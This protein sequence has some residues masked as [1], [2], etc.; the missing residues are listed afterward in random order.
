MF[1]RPEVM[2]P[3]L[4]IMAMSVVQQFSGMSI[5]RSYVVKIFNEVFKSGNDL[6]LERQ[7]SIEC[8]PEQKVAGEAYLAAIVIGIT[9]LFSS[10]L[11]SKLLYHFRRRS[12]YIWSGKYVIVLYGLVGGV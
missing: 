5:L 2:K 1:K 11:L 7:N 6:D 3:F 12:L 8:D 9:R 10:L 4:I